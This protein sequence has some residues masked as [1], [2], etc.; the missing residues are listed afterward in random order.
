[1]NYFEF[2]GIIDYIFTHDKEYSMLCKN[3]ARYIEKNYRWD[4]IIDNFQKLI[5]KISER[6]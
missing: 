1:M 4:V 3:A 2:E 6:A 5:D